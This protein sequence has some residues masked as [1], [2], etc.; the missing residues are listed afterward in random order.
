MRLIASL[1]PLTALTL[2]SM[3][4][5]GCAGNSPRKPADTQ[6]K[7]RDTSFY[8]NCYDF[9]SRGLPPPA[10]CPQRPTG[11]RRTVTPVPSMNPGDALPD[12]PTRGVLGGR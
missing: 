12:L 3:L 4:L 7:S 2:S 1:T 6:D 10:G 5:A 11:A 9:E 8:E